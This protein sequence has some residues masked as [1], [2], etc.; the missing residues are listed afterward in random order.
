M[1]NAPPEDR[2]ICGSRDFAP[3]GHRALGCK[4]SASANLKVLGMAYFPIHPDSRLRIATLFSSEGGIENYTLKFW[5]ILT[6]LN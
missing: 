6:V 3:R 4:I 2:E 1:E 5:V